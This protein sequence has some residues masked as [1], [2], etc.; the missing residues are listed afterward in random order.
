MIFDNSLNTYGANNVVTPKQLNDAVST[1]DIEA[2]AGKGRIVYNFED[3]DDNTLVDMSTNKLHMQ[4]KENLIFRIQGMT[5]P[6]I[7][8]YNTAGTTVTPPATASFSSSATLATALQ[9]S[10][11]HI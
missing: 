5:N 6:I 11:I 4:N 2:I 10:L 7:L 3:T 9:L 1:V 8:E